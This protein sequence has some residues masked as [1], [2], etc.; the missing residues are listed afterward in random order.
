VTDPYDLL[1]VGGGPA[2]C[3]T[4]IS[5][6]RE[7]LRVALV[8]RATFPRPKPC[9]EG[10]MPS[11]IQVL[12]ELGLWEKVRALGRPFCGVR[13]TTQAG[14][15]AEGRF[16]GS[17]GLGIAREE[18]DTA[19]WRFASG[20]EG[21]T[22]FEGRAATGIAAGLLAVCDGGRS[23]AAA[24]LGVKRLTPVRERF[25]FSARFETAAD[26]G[27][28]V[29]VYLGRGGEIYVTPLPEGAAV[30]VLCEKRDVDAPPER[31]YEALL[32]SCPGL[33]ARLGRRVTAVRGLG[34]LAQTSDR[35]C[36][37]GWLLAGDAAGA[38]DPI[39]GDGMA[40]ALQT[41]RC[42]GLALARAARGD[43]GALARYAAQRRRLLRARTWLAAGVLAAARRPTAA[44]AAVGAL[45][46][47]PPVFRAILSLF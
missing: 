39:I 28:L 5:A 33:A 35:V 29:E 3:A 6:A 14:R 4:A 8:D 32:G 38:L 25:G 44:E 24:A 27:D 45:S 23:Q 36:G 1:V 9:G 43:D 18:L 13:Y 10:L 11:G 42:A 40:A 12:R 16:P 20:C 31:L 37:A 41:G 7:G 22:A 26:L 2:G 30:A 47:A 17:G 46:L 34:P 21:V 15:T 19:L